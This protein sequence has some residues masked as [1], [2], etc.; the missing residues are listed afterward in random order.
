VRVVAPDQGRRTLA[1]DTQTPATSYIRGG[2]LLTAM[3][4]SQSHPGELAI[5]AIL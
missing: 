1:Q 4:V 5:L 2:T 3:G